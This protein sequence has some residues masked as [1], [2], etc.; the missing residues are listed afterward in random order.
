MAQLTICEETF[1]GAASSRRVAHELEIE[2]AKISAADLIRLRVEMQSEAQGPQP[3]VSGTDLNNFASPPASLDIAIAE[4]FRGLESN[5][6][7]LIVNGRQVRTL[8]EIIPLDA[9]NAATFLKLVPLKG[10]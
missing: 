1:G 2:F 7:F 3:R 4:A 10:G 8:D 6:F 5:A 9:V